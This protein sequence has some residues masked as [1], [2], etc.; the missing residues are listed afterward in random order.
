MTTGTCRDVRLGAALS[1]PRL[2]TLIETAEEE[3]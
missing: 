2:G 3:Q 1:V